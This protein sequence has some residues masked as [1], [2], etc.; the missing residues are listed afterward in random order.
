[1]PHSHCIGAYEEYEGSTIIYGQG[2]FIFDNSD[3]EYW[4]TSL[5]VIL[6]IDN[7]LQVEC[8]PITQK[9][10]VVRLAKNEK[11]VIILKGY[12]KRSEEIMQKDFVKEKYRKFSI[13]YAESYLR[14]IA[15]F[16]KWMSRIDRCLFSGK[17]LKLKYNRKKL[18]AI[19][20]VIECEAHRELIL[21]L[22]KNKEK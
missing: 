21:T 6:K 16:G 20:N 15:G 22:L 19:Q 13:E 2:N 12:K 17:L 3:N 11:A 4:Q 5:L 8:I 1:M 7:G 10:N 14:K 9:G 18:L